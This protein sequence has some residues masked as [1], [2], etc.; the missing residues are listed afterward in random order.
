MDLGE[1]GL[2]T[3]DK[4]CEV[5]SHHEIQTR[6]VI[7]YIIRGAWLSSS[8]RKADE[9]RLRRSHCQIPKPWGVETGLNGGGPCNRLVPPACEPSP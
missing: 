1:S 2:R 6:D 8:R 9:T 4:S 5:I 7:I 3:E